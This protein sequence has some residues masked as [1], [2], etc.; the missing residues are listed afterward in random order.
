MDQMHN[1][2]NNTDQR[3]TECH[4]PIIIICIYLHDFTSNI[5]IIRITTVILT[6]ITT[7]Q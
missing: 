1:A 6:T 4:Y 2:D 7:S 3:L 5:S